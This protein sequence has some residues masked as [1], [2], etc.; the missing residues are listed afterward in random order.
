MRLTVFSFFLG[1]FFSFD[2]V[3]SSSIVVYQQ[4]PKLKGYLC[5]PSGVG[6]FPVVIYNHGGLG[7]MV[8]GDPLGTC[9][10]LAKAG[11]VGFSPMRRKTVPMKGHPQDV[12][13]A[14]EFVKD[15]SFVN[16]KKIGM[17]GFS[18]GAL[19]TYMVSTRSS[20]LKAVVVMA[21]APARGMLNKF[22]PKASSVTA[23]TL[24]LVSENDTAANSR[25][26]KDHV[27]LSEM[28][29]SALQEAG[30]DVRLIIYPP[31]KGNG[32][33][34]FYKVRDYWTDVKGFFRKHL[35]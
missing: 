3:A 4:S 35:K 11:F 9:E 6:P 17:M 30:K 7:Q 34:L 14:L 22:L 25:E 26:G 31:Y 8:G 13:A 24:V 28:V 2:G 33:E 23:P 18:R 12:M 1:L 5:K 19:L 15:Q 21:P 27:K 10:A 20:D 29:T 32:H 16:S